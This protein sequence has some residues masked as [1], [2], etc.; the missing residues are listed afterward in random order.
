M[1]S[2]LV[3]GECQLGLKQLSVVCDDYN[4]LFDSHPYIKHLT[5]MF[6]LLDITNYLTMIY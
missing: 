4:S 2:E 1:D 3:S 6:C 5:H